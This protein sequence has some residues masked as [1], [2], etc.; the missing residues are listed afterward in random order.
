MYFPAIWFIY[1]HISMS[2]FGR[3]AQFISKNCTSC[4]PQFIFP[5]VWSINKKLLPLCH[6]RHVPV[7]L[8]KLP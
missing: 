7:N 2:F 1:L 3:K 6:L 4:C 8:L 5:G